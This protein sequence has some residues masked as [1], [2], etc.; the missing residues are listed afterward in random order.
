MKIRINIIF[1]GIVLV[2][3]HFGNNG[4]EAVNTMTTM[5]QTIAAKVRRLR[6][7]IATINPDKDI[8]KKE[9]AILE[10]KNLEKPVLDLKSFVQKEKRKNPDFINQLNNEGMPPRII[11]EELEL[12][13]RHDLEAIG[14]S[15]GIG[16]YRENS[17]IDRLGAEEWAIYS[18]IENLSGPVMVFKN[19][20]TRYKNYFEFL[21]ENKRY[22]PQEAHVILHIATYV[23]AVRH[24]LTLV[25]KDAGR[26]LL[27]LLKTYVDWLP[28][29]TH[30]DESV[31]ITMR[32][33]SIISVTDK[34]NKTMFDWTNDLINKV[35]AASEVL[36]KRNISTVYMED[37]LKQL[38][39]I[40]MMLKGI[41]RTET[42]KRK[43]TTRDPLRTSKR[44][45]H[46]ETGFPYV[47]PL[48]E[49]EK[50]N[51]AR[52]KALNLSTE[53]EL[54]EVSDVAQES[55]PR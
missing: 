44:D 49:E 47:R 39:E 11:E 43:L 37:S 41:I 12:C 28:E 51:I 3:M 10:I 52:I 40:A 9:E 16:G 26:Y 1:V 55:F 23:I 4:S 5:V 54:V 18:M 13:F 22:S 34:N 46:P 7:N 24:A 53:R 32:H 33:G 17:D 21:A 42:G 36:K 20:N 14:M 25:E 35:K 2:T 45:F 50:K 19:L 6:D 38:R 27:N 48:T 31:E 8:Q 30:L 15:L 29:A